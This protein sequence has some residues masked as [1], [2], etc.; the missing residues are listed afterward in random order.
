VREN[1]YVAMTR[2]RN[3]NTAYVIT[4]PDPDTEAHTRNPDGAVTARDVLARVLTTSGAEPSAHQAQHD[5]RQQWESM[6][7]L[8]GEYRTIAQASRPSEEVMREYL[9]RTAARGPGRRASS[10]IVGLIPEPTWPLTPEYRDALGELRAKI[11]TRATAVLND[12]IANNAPWT[13]ALDPKRPAA[14]RAIAAYR[15]TYAITDDDPLGSTPTDPTQRLDHA[16]AA[17]AI[18]PPTASR[19]T[20]DAFTHRSHQRPPTPN[21]G[22][23]L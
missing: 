9:L 5:E 17:Q 15:D 12:A 7:Q 18:R 1:L 21:R 3:T 6:T 8:V 14:A 4:E 16:R 20:P 13:R 10:Q 11:E 23:T 2:G 19:P 22:R